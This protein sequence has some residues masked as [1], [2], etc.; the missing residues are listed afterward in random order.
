[1]LNA[2]SLKG[3]GVFTIGQ[4]L[5]ILKAVYLLKVA[6]NIVSLRRFVVSGSSDF[7]AQPKHP[8]DSK[9]P[10]WTNCMLWSRSR[11]HPSGWMDFFLIPAY[12]GQSS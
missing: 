1:M 4:R 12:P 10:W 5:A 2:D 11:V 8:N 7:A 9:G 6:H 3:V